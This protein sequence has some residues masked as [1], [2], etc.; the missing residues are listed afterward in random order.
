MTACVDKC[1]AKCKVIKRDTAL[2]K[3]NILNINSYGCIHQSINK[4][5]LKVDL[6]HIYNALLLNKNIYIAF[7]LEALDINISYIK[8]HETNLYNKILDNL[9]KEQKDRLYRVQ[10]QQE[11]QTISHYDTIHTSK[12]CHC[13]ECLGNITIHNTQANDSYYG[14]NDYDY[15]DDYDDDDDYDNDDNHHHD[16]S[17]S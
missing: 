13:S 17:S 10:L 9:D 15:D 12:Y 6:Y 11:W 16:E 3:E 14:S 4:Y 8:S 7:L 2:I 1:I 5:D